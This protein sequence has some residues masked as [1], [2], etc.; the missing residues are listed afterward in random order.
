VDG[1]SIRILPNTAANP[2]KLR[3]SWTR[4]NTLFSEFRR[5]IHPRATL[6]LAID[7]IL[8]AISLPAALLL[9]LSPGDVTQFSAYQDATIAAI[10][11][12]LGVGFLTFTGSGL[13]KA[14]WRYVSLADVIHVAQAAGLAIVVFGL[15]LFFVNRLEAIPR[16][17]PI[18]Q[19]LLLVTLMTGS[20]VVYREVTLRGLR[21]RDSWRIPTLVV[22]VNANSELFIR[23]TSNNPNA[24]FQVIAVLDW[25]GRNVGRS[26]HRVP[27]MGK[28]GDAQEVVECIRRMKVRPQRILISEQHPRFDAED[29]FSAAELLGLSVAYLPS[30]GELLRSGKPGSAVVNDLTTQDL[31]RR[32]MVVLNDSELRG[33]IE[34][35]R[36][37]VTGAGGSIGSELCKQ[38]AQ[39]KPAELVMLDLS[40]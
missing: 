10:P 16:S 8:C 33:M 27:V 6:V 24:A 32:P 30:P 37:L 18:I 4:L 23:A 40:E 17:V 13:Y 25:D 36:V 7:L 34:G 11:I 31:L 21:S 5:E 15:F 22:G 26:V 39:F 3:R 1:N 29:L 12:L 20:R 35:R 9:R 14:F 38:V 2:G 19:Y 28:V